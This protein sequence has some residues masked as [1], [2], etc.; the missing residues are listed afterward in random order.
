MQFQSARPEIVRAINQRWLLKTWDERRA[1]HA[2][3]SWQKLE[4]REFAGM[5]KSLC[6]SD[7]VREAGNVRFLM[8]FH[9]AWLGEL[10]GFDCHNQYLDEIPSGAFQDA[11]LAT[12]RHVAK[13]GLPV[14]TAVEMQDH[15]G[16]PVIYERLLLPFRLD[17][18]T[19]ERILAS[20]EMVS[21]DGAFEHRN[22]M[23]SAD[24]P[25]SFAVYATIQTPGP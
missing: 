7:V 5:M 24:T 4:G 17:G 10:Y 16:R 9:S 18:S 14:F 13:T 12:Y 21:L 15:G 23:R 6:F 22:L 8:R 19:V 1:G 3:P 20:L 11:L 25:S 2:L